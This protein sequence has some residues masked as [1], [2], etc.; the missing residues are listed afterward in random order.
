MPGEYAPV[1]PNVRWQMPI[2]YFNA[3]EEAA[4]RSRELDT[5]MERARALQLRNELSR[6]RLAAEIQAKMARMPR[7]SGTLPAS[8]PSY[9]APA[10]SGMTRPFSTGYT[11]AAGNGGAAG[12]AGFNPGAV[13]GI[14]PDDNVSGDAL[15][16][17]G[18]N[19][20]EQP[21][22]SLSLFPSADRT[23]TTQTAQ[24][25]QFGNGSIPPQEQASQQTGGAL[26]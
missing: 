5:S 2:D 13:D 7:Y 17:V 15:G 23:Q 26:Q 9:S 12:T 18:S 10:G 8:G 19:P 22:I 3:A 20:Q 4:Q 1:G 14:S 6:E 16:V 25:G 21:S 24:T 11:P